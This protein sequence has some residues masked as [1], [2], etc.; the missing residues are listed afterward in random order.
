VLS[1]TVRLAFCPDDT[2]GAF[3]AV[4]ADA[5]VTGADVA[6]PVL[7]AA[8][9]AGVLVGVLPPPHAA[10]TAAAALAPANCRK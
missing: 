7:E 3:V 10:R 1:H 5:A 2:A 6:P 8:L 4:A 9:G